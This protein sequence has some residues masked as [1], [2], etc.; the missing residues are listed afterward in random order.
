MPDV[1]KNMR[2]AI[3]VFDLDSVKWLL[4]C[5]VISST[6]TP[7]CM[8]EP[9]G[10]AL[11]LIHRAIYTMKHPQGYWGSQLICHFRINVL[12]M[13]CLMPH[14][15]F[16]YT[17][18]VGSRCKVLTLQIPYGFSVWECLWYQ[19]A[20]NMTSWLLSWCSHFLKNLGKFLCCH[21]TQSHV[22]QLLC[23]LEYLSG[24]L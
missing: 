16:P 8:A 18:N 1:H 23:C 15:L 7:A 4:L 20:Y 11:K 12:K 22:L 9:E 6:R 2:E 5:K 13:A 10:C 17:V 24:F 14:N 19:R 21:L 3:T